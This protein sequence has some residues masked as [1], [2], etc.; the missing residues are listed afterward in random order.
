MMVSG[1]RGRRWQPCFALMMIAGAC[2][3]V[4]P[5]QGM[6]QTSDRQAIER[7][8]RALIASYPEVLERADG[9]A[10]VWKDGTRMVIDDGRGAKTHEVLLNTADIKDMF[11]APYPAGASGLPPAVNA[12]PG[13]ARNAPFFNKM[14]GDCLSGGVA[15]NLVDI[16]WLPKKWGKAIKATRI[17]GVD[18]RL[19]A[20]SLELD[21][22]PPRFDVFL[23]PSAGTYNCR[24]IAGTNRVS[25]HG[26]GIA[27]DIS[28]KQSDYWLWAKGKG[29]GSVAYK[30]RIPWEIV[31]VFERHGFVWGGKWYHYDTMHFEY[32][33][34]IIAASK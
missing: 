4:A 2:T 3:I 9:N 23:F 22:L 17:N 14:Y 24:A 30:N 8:I 21:K 34:E 7:N 16:I 20:V 11:F 10:L 18:K 29:E 12:D 32:R 1:C 28:T 27:I 25:A 19:T 31:E 15:P 5:G 6:A 26:H 13:R 33:P